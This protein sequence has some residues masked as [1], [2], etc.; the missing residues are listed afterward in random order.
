MRSALTWLS[1]LVLTFVFVWAAAAKML[2]FRAWREA[3]SAYGFPP[4]A[5]RVIAPAVPL[6]ELAAAVALTVVS[7]KLGAAVSLVLLSG[8]SLAVL[9]A[10]VRRGNRVPCGCFGRTKA[11]DYRIMLGRN[12]VLAALAAVI[13]LSDETEGLLSGMKVPAAGEM[14][15]AILAIVG[16]GVVAIVLWQASRVL[17]DPAALDRKGRQI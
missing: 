17:T 5:S 6:V 12:A 16:I 1:A 10:R 7:V 2:R 3:L 9:R 11:R 15:P 14:F 8:F 4:S 13:L